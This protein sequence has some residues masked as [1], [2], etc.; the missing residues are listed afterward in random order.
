MKWVQENI[1][2][3]G[4]IS[5]MVT[6]IGQ[7]AGASSIAYHMLSPLSTGLFH[8]AILQSGAVTTPYTF[9]SSEDP[10]CGRD[11]IKRL[12]CDDNAMLLES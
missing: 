8:K 12:G 2:S 6:V 5:S 11:I 10:D 4:G 7:G 9:Y 1:A 3:F